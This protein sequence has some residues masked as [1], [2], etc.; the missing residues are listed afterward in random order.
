[1][2][3]RRSSYL[4]AFAP[5]LPPISDICIVVI[6][7][8]RSEHDFDPG[9]L[10]CVVTLCRVGA[11]PGCRGCSVMS[12]PPFLLS[13]ALA[14]GTPGAALAPCPLPLLSK[15]QNL[16]FQMNIDAQHCAD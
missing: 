4:L 11:G 8:T 16:L 12:L 7:V 5:D 10:V 9:S 3:L 15:Q 6:S 13:P 14:S 2:K 1:M